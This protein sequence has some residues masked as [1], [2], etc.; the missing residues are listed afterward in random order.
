MSARS[1]SV[2]GV[3]PAAGASRRMGRPKALLRIDGD[4]FLRRVV[5]ALSEGGCDPVYVVVV[6]G[7]EAAAEEASAAGARVLHNPDPG[8]GPVT[9]LRLALATMD[10]GAD[11]VVYLPLDHALVESRHVARLLAEANASRAP[12]ALPVH[13]GK[14]GHPAFFARTLFDELSDPELEGGAR[15]VVHRY[16]DRARL[17]PTEDPAVVVD[18]DT[19]EA[20]ERA[21]ALH[22]AAAAKEAP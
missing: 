9:S 5:R 12:L 10:E 15:T 7:D 11:G 6:E 21:L 18:I 13:R 22:E 14:R 17:L 16:L 19:P 4:T 8:E 3:I 1:P 20:Y 2:A